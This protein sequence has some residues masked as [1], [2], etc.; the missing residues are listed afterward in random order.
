LK[1]LKCPHCE[2]ELKTI[3]VDRV[4][5]NGVLSFSTTR[6][7]YTPSYHIMDWEGLR[8]S[9]C[10]HPLPE[11]FADKQTDQDVVAV[12]VWG[13]RKRVLLDRHDLRFDIPYAELS[14]ELPR[15][16]EPANAKDEVDE[17][18]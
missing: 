9:E 17:A 8:C 15:T 2:K 4:I 18:G 13:E 16:L 14:D 6:G 5:T 3:R 7:K 1:P 11:D 10:G 12:K